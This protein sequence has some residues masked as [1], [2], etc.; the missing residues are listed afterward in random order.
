MP[1]TIQVGGKTVTVA[2]AKQQWALQ[3]NTNPAETVTLSAPTTGPAIYV[4][5]TVG[6]TS[7][8]TD[9]SGQTVAPDAQN[10]LLKFDGSGASIVGPT[11]PPNAAPDQISTA[12]PGL[13]RQF[14]AGRGGR[15]RRLALCAGQCH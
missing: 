9:S 10:Q 12:T 6:N 13:E 7:S 1:D 15:P 3:L 8:S 5:Q 11:P 2:A 14:G 4:G